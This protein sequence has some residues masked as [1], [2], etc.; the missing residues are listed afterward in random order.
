MNV[1]RHFERVTKLIGLTLLLLF[2]GGNSW[3]QLRVTGKVVSVNGLPLDF[4]TV[5][6]KG[7][8]I[9]T[10]TIQDGSFFLNNVPN[11][12]T[13]IISSIGYKGQ[14]VLLNGRAYVEIVLEEDAIQI[15]ELV[16][17]ALGISREKKA[18]GYA[19]QVVKSDQLTQS[20]NVSLSGALQ[21]KISG[22]E[23][24]PSSGMPGAS[25]KITIR[26][27]RSFTGDN[28][29]LYVVDGMPISSTGDVSTGHSISGTDFANRAVDIDPNDIES[30]NIL[31]GQAASAL[32]GMRA[33]NGV[34]VIT[35]KSG[36][37]AKNSKPEITFNTNVAVDIISVMPKLQNEFAQGS[38]GEYNPTA[39][40]SW[41]QKIVDLPDD[42]NYGG[43]TANKYTN[44]DGLKP[45]MYY[46]PQRA[47]AGLDPWVKPQVYNN[48]EDF[49]TRGT[50]LS[51]SLNIAQGFDKGNYSFSIGNTT[52]TGI[53]PGTGMNR[54]NAKLGADAK[55]SKN[56]STGFSGN[57]VESK[58]SKQSSANDGIVATI[59]PAPPSYDLA[60]IPNYYKGN[61]YKQNN[62]R[63]TNGF[64][65][66]YWSIDNN[67]FTEN[68]QR[69]F[70]NMYVKYST[71]L[72]TENHKIDVKY[73]LGID[74]YTTNYK[75]VWGYGHVNG[76]G[77]VSHYSYTNNEL[78][79]LLTASYNWEINR[80]LNFDALVG[81][82]IVEH[83]S[84]YT[85]A[86]GKDFNF[87]G[88]N[89]I[90]NASVYYV[91]NSYRRGQTSPRGLTIGNFGNLSLA[92][93]SMLF[94]NITGRNDMVSS[95]PRNN[96]SFFYPS[97][98]LGWIFTELPKL[99]NDFLTYGKLR[100]SYAEVGQA[101]TYYD[102]YYTTPVY[103]GG[104]SSGTPIAYPIGG[105][106]AYTLDRTVY[107]PN[108]K[109]QNT[110][111]YEIGTDLTFLNGLLSLNYTF[112]RQNVVDQI[113]EVPLA[114]S[115]GSGSLMT[116]GG[117]I[118]T[119][120]HEVTLSALPVDSKNIKWNMA[121][122]F[123]KIDN[124]VD[125]LA[126][127]VNS[128][129]LGGFVEPQIRAG[130]GSKFPVIYG[131]SYLR[132]DAGQI[133]VDERG[134]P[135]AGE[136]KIIGTVSP[137]FMLGFNTSLEI[138]KFRISAV[139]DW[140]QGGQMYSGTKGL[141]DYYG[142]S[143]NSANIRKS[144][145][146]MFGKEAVKVTGKDA[147]GNE[148]YAP[149]DITISGSNTQA[150][151]EIDNKISESMIY[152]NS[153]IKLREVA[154]NYPVYSKKGVIINLNA[155]ARNILLWSTFKGLDPEATQGNNNMGGA[156]ERF[157]LPGT[158]SFGFGLNLKF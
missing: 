45:G 103:D 61:L 92:Y 151:F 104:F 55:L 10:N 7:S 36:K 12:S 87:P 44:A 16:V 2:A 64:D 29:P 93:K 116:N 20:G 124:Y 68:L 125:E 131:V 101:G 102:T 46:V 22:L 77:E 60:G 80:D 15:N 153:F 17:T 76:K 142:I 24:M 91:S 72:N 96:R 26:G 53:I 95:M 120:S 113:F 148:T 88:W 144:E 143:Q 154:L 129:F 90:D 127:G 18:L 70:G 63:G 13:L 156:F 23:I 65:N 123:S 111:S 73:Q 8:K 135:Q 6:V 81:N 71:K 121:F 19:V 105:V 139:L 59:Y 118:H 37:G 69:F 85:Y 48:A 83:N 3:A 82:E 41:G 5:V 39:S 94:L 119:N 133:V 30:V 47:N 117:S 57:F 128:I 25:S 89:H 130:I 132:N 150:F 149:N 126:P 4:V 141:L 58:I 66:C 107:D 115:T 140:K 145:T 98:S 146:F 50:T 21:G 106:V 152:D 51:N 74:S 99:K 11:E 137:D 32:Y 114:G 122:N 79:S 52:S 134:F 31:K 62:Y 147:S 97:A 158:S 9:A 33:S 40:S 54:Y 138:Y 42:I 108:L 110:K 14:E 38:G 136:E 75:D 27:S 78:N 43:N 109:P 84:R 34:I 56:W 1:K 67:K 112:S 155:F 100:A 49:F 86:Y 35:T 28:S 157:S